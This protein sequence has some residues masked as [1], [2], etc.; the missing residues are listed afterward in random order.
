MATI[1]QRS[2]GWEAQ[3][4][5][6]G[7]PVVTKTFKRKVDAE[8]WA[9][10]VESEIV[11]GVFRD[12]A[13]AAQFTF[14][15]LLERYLREVTPT[16]K[17]ASAER[18]QIL[19]LQRDPL[20]RCV[21]SNLSA[22]DVAAWRDRRLAVVSGST[23]NRGLN[24][25]SHVLNVARKE[26]G[27]P[28]HNPVADIRRPKNNRPRRV[29][30]SPTAEAQ[31]IDALGV[32]ERDERG[33]L[34]PGSRNP[35][36]RPLVILA[37]ETGMRRSE[38]LSTRW[39]DVD[40]D[41][42]FVRLHD[43]KNGET[44]DVPLSTRGV[45]ELSNLVRDPSGWVFPISPEAV[46]KAF[47]RAVRRAG[48]GDFHFHDL[49]HEATSRLA[50]KLSNVLELSAMTGHKTLSMLQRYYHPDPSELALKLG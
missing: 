45:A 29:R 37:L 1:R 34:Q 17:G 38:L 7:I 46:K 13:T 43:T 36:M 24:L 19:A 40:L 25:I 6:R 3:I 4:R 50:T 28:V 9:A 33:R 12:R 41:R 35:W 15:D 31:L 49:R 48:L 18:V 47:S 30:L 10:V 2:S 21:L 39:I 20:S 11:R 26:W 8:S 5:R 27:I 16:K 14:G 22:H 23:V 42:R 44:R 32:V